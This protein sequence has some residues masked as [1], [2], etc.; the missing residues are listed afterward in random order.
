VWAVRDCVGIDPDT[1]WLRGA[2]CVGRQATGDASAGM[3]SME[4]VSLV[5]TLEAWCHLR[6]RQ[7]G[8]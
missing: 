6:L 5:H 2:A 4:V 1:P 3:A 7:E 8:Y